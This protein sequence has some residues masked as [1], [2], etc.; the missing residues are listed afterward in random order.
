M[1]R[2][3]KGMDRVV[4]ELSR[5]DEVLLLTHVFPDGDA[6]GS[7]FALGLGLKAAGKK[8]EVFFGADHT[9]PSIY[10]F[11]VED[12]LILRDEKPKSKMAITVDCANLSRVWGAQLLQDMDLVVNID[13]HPDNSQFGNINVVNVEASAVTEIIYDLLKKM[14]VAIDKKIATTL[15][16]GIVTDTGKFQYSN[17]T[18]RAHRIAAELMDLGINPNQIFKNVYE[19]VSWQYLQ[20]SALALDR[21]EVSCN[22]SYVYSYLNREDF[23]KLDAGYDDAE[24]IINLL[25]A[26]KG[27]KVACLAKQTN[28]VYKVSLRSDGEVDVGVIARQFD[29]GGHKAASG[30]TYQG[31]LKDL[32]EK[33]HSLVHHAICKPIT[34]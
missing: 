20:L 14:E 4:R 5:R 3:S 9:I 18:A 22:D 13:H 11:L 28:E 21:V 34:K 26:L 27:I 23:E 31:N 19:Q 10:Q 15:Y 16:V 7:L 29:G 33:L 2:L 6:I 24:E 17:T 1:N 12:S 32:T 25:R 8:V 30:F